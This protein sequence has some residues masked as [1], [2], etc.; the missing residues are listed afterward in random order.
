MRDLRFARY[1]AGLRAVAELLWLSSYALLAAILVNLV[2][3]AT[4]QG[5]ELIDSLADSPNRPR[6]ILT[7]L[8]SAIYCA[9]ACSISCASI[10]RFAHVRRTTHE[11]LLRARR[12][13]PY[14]LAVAVLAGCSA[15]VLPLPFVAVFVPTVMGVCILAL[16]LI[17]PTKTT[18]SPSSRALTTS[19]AI[20]AVTGLGVCAALIVFPV[21][22][23]RALGA[24]SLVYL[25]TG[26]WTIV[27]SYAFVILPKR[28]GLPALIFAPLLI[29]AVFSTINDNHGIRLGPN[30]RN[31][32]TP[33]GTHFDAWLH[34]ACVPSRAACPVYL[35]AAQ[36][37][38][39]RAA[40]W[41]AA[42][43]GALD[44]N[45]RGTFSKHLFAISAV[46]GGALGAASF[47]AAKAD[48]EADPSIDRA[49]A[50]RAFL[51][52]DYLSPLVGA[53]MFPD[54]VARFV[55]I[56]LPHFD[57]AVAFE[58]ALERSWRLNFHSDR[59]A[60]DIHSLYA[61]KGGDELPS[62]LLNATNVETGKRFIIS[63]LAFD[64]AERGDAYYAYDPS[65]AYHIDSMPLS[66]AVHLGAR[67]PF[68]SPHG[69][70]D[71]APAGTGVWGRLVDGGY[72]DNSGT[73]TLSDLLDALAKRVV[74]APHHAGLSIVPEFIV[75]VISS[76]VDTPPPGDDGRAFAVHRNPFTAPDHMMR[77]YQHVGNVP[78]RS[79]GLSELNSPVEALLEAREAHADAELHHLAERVDDL[80]TEGG[81]HCAMARLGGNAT[82]SPVP[83]FEEFSYA[84]ALA[85][86]DFAGV[87]QSMAHGSADHHA[88]VQLVRPGL[89]WTLSARSRH[90]LDILSVEAVEKQTPRKT[91]GG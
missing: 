44:A 21:S 69:V 58:A 10:L 85:S 15:L 9:A 64:A 35:V 86:E 31:V 66:T 76:D 42:V 52:D 51:G 84:K 53:M 67:F 20:L 89:G 45:T 6:A 50:M 28:A 60:R 56:S 77:V 27:A 61:G 90:A 81:L 63:N 88:L 91:A 72:Y 13:V 5:S 40:Y 3:P 25:G 33:L 70:L 39:V 14:W 82:C 23:A 55:P 48:S 41:T 38:G 87:M 43:L 1:A 4:S 8:A 74:N 47:V 29:F 32:P 75:I 11:S 68:I 2:I 30:Q 54:F 34:Q 49:P 80:A 65:A 62:L 73:A 78:E 24:W 46:S 19:A 57:R 79:L 36:G 7:L 37:G 17:G 83:A 71:D 18:P 59:F 16:P 26:F 12:A 22:A